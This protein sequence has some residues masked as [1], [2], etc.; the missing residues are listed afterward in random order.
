VKKADKNLGLTIMSLDWY[1]ENVRMEIEDHKFYKPVGGIL[2]AGIHDRVTETLKKWKSYIT[3]RDYNTLI[4]SKDTYMIPEFYGIPKIH[5]NPIKLRPIV[6][7]I[8]W[9]TTDLAKWLDGQLQPLVRMIWWIVPNS[10]E[11]VKALEW[12]PPIGIALHD[13]VLVTADVTSLYTRINLQE[14]YKIIYEFLI[15]FEPFG[16]D[17]N[18]AKMIIDLTK[19]VMENNYFQYRH[20][21]FKQI[22]GTAMGCNM[23]PVF[24]NLFVAAYEWNFIF[25]STKEQPCY[26]AR[27]LDDILFVW[28]NSCNLNVFKAYM[29]S[30]SPSLEFVFTVGTTV[31]FLDLEINLGSMEFEFRPYSK[32]NN[33]HLYTDPR[34]YNE[35]HIVYN[36]IQGECVRLCRNSTTKVDYDRAIDNLRRCLAKRKY[37]REIVEAQ[38]G[39]T[40][41]ELRSNYLVIENNIEID[42]TGA[43]DDLQT[44]I[45]IDNIPGRHWVKKY[46]K[47]YI[48]FLK[49]YHHE[50]TFPEI[51]IVV[52]KGRTL[53]DIINTSV[54]R[55]LSIQARSG[56]SPGDTTPA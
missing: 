34:T 11:V 56:L 7:S 38:I 52:K 54:K 35:E 48:K 10:M 45:F 17:I 39:K 20:Q 46:L 50:H 51:Q 47:D 40:N 37:P 43:P 26:Y 42:I 28:S 4:K 12:D 5:K 9:A 53:M 29:N 27:Y 49:E 44:R 8:D 24:A 55:V 2:P 6:S 22:C 18:R 15:S 30:F 14:S 31:N 25:N 21:Y 36:W 23:A 13:V 41:Y 3:S 1:D 32:A 16:C 33:P 19:T